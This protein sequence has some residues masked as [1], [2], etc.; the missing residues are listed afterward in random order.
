M[1]LLNALLVDTADNQSRFLSSLHANRT[2]VL[3]FVI[4]TSKIHLAVVPSLKFRSPQC[5]MKPGG[6]RVSTHLAFVSKCLSTRLEMPF[7]AL[8]YTPPSHLS[9]RVRCLVEFI[10]RETQTHLD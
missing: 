3:N 8:C 1:L 10:K 9:A 4:S 7:Y 6:F 5:Q 2:S